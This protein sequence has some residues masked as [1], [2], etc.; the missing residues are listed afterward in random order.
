MTTI[1]VDTNVIVRFVVR[2]PRAQYER[3]LKLMEQ[4]SEEK[5]TL[6]VS[7]AIVGEVAAVLHHSYKL[8]LAE[9]AAAL[10][11]FARSPGIDVEE[12]QIV[13]R[14]LEQSRDLPDIDFIDAYA[15]GKAGADGLSVASFDQDLHKKLGS[16]VHP[17]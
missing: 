16:S 3:A 15:A 6:A 8:P 1:V 2:E 17:F 4:V 5:I 9:V 10:L 14:A 12:R 11:A 13:E 7:A